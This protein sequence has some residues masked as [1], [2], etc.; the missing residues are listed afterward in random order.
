MNKFFIVVLLFSLSFSVKAGFKSKHPEITDAILELGIELK[1]FST[2]WPFY[3]N[4]SWKKT[5]PVEQ[6]MKV[7]F[8]KNSIDKKFFSSMRVGNNTIL[9]QGQ[10]CRALMDYYFNGRYSTL[11]SS[12]I[13]KDSRIIHKY[14]FSSIDLFQFPA[15]FQGNFVTTNQ[16][17]GKSELTIK[18]LN[19][20][21]NQNIFVINEKARGTFFVK[22]SK[23]FLESHRKLQQK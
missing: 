16:V 22:P 15:N 20:F 11:I 21:R 19:R 9:S 10:T 17:P 5:M 3:C 2:L 8:V 7:K 4:P 13:A 14:G 6:T 1:D 23:R 12:F 18:L